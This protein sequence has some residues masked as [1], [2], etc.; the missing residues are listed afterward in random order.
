MSYILE[1]LADSEQA[2]RQLAATPTYS[3]LP[4]VGENTQQRRVWPYALAGTVLVNLALLQLWLRPAPP[5]SIATRLQPTPPAL[6]QIPA[7][8]P[9]PAVV[10]PPQAAATAAAA[11]APRAAPVAIDAG[12]SAQAADAT[13]KEPAPPP[14]PRAD[15][16]SVARAPAG[17]IARTATP[18][19]TGASASLQTR[20]PAPGIRA[21]AGTQLAPA[22]AAV[23]RTE[24]SAETRN[25]AP[26]KPDG[27]GALSPAL[28]KELPALS[29]AGYIRGEGSA[30]MVIV[31]DRLVREGDEVAPGVKLESIR[32]DGLVFSYKGYRFKR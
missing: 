16:G 14:P 12:P 20:R 1:A 22:A 3:L 17:V 5:G 6:A 29:V 30:S 8:V 23:P 31:N 28:Q 10:S 32:G 19:S 9:P 11:A 13:L 18:D 4:V 25:Q 27:D 15:D 7:T 24:A 2:R 21:K 26:P